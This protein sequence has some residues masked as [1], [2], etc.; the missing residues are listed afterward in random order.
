VKKRM[1]ASPL[2]SVIIPSFNQVEGLEKTARAYQY[3]RV[4]EQPVDQPHLEIIVADG[5][6][7]DGTQEWLNDNKDL[8]DKISIDPDSGIY[9]GMHNG[10]R[11][12]TSKWVLF[13]GTGDIPVPEG[14]EKA[15]SAIESTTK[16]TPKMFAFGVHLLPPREP[17]VPEFYSPSWGNSLLWRNT[18]HHQGAIYSR[19][20]LGENPFYLQFPVLADYHLHLRIWK[21]KV[22]CN[23]HSFIISEVAPGGVSRNFS[24]GLYREEREMKSTVLTSLEYLPQILFTRFKW[25]FKKLSK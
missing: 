13:M 14:L 24:R 8:F 19:E 5:A 3:W 2:L 18:I 17:G 11:L 23:C 6:S 25:L 12:A 16:S 21:S 4:N 7:T 20:L 1:K 9:E 15:L 10:L 22:I